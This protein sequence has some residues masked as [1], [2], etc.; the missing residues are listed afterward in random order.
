LVINAAGPW[1]DFA[2]QALGLSTRYIGGTKGSHLV[3]D[4][5]ALREAIGDHEFF[6]ENKDGRIVLIFPLFNKVLIGTSDIPIEDPDEALCTEEEIDYFLEMIAKVFPGIEVTREHIA[7]QFSGVRPLAFST[8]KT[9]GQITRDHSIQVTEGV[10]TGLEFPVYSLVGGKWT[11]YRAFSEEVADKTLKA[12]GLTRQKTTGGLSIG[13][14]HAYPKTNQEV[15]RL[16]EG[17]SAWTGVP[18]EQVRRLLDRYGTRAEQVSSYISKDTDKPLRT[19]PAFTRRE[20]A[21]LGSV[22]KALHLDDVIL[23]RTMLAMLGDINREQLD[24][25]AEVMG[26]ALGWSKKQKSAEVARAREILA[27]KHGLRV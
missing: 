22:E 16:V 12:L 15:N 4:H 13:G 9:T 24:E 3:L 19:L 21:F 27:S 14:G 7:F 1:I 8:A 26:E 20:V 11:S 5:P 2:N 25:L 17:L 23:R 18:A 6:F 10:W